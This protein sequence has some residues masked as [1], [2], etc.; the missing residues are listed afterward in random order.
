MSWNSQYVLLR[1]CCGRGAPDSASTSK[2]TG[3]GL[4]WDKSPVWMCGD[5][6]CLLAAADTEHKHVFVVRPWAEVF[7][8]AQVSGWVLSP[9]TRTHAVM[10]TDVGAISVGGRC[11][12]PRVYRPLQGRG[13]LNAPWSLLEAGWCNSLTFKCNLET[14]SVLHLNLTQT[15]MFDRAWVPALYFHSLF[16]SFYVFPFIFLLILPFVLNISTLAW[17]DIP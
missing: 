13:K 9:P 6:T 12:S 7:T 4:W 11:G 1:L 2:F 15:S 16:H 3:V 5:E 8:E 17:P 14:L 10:C